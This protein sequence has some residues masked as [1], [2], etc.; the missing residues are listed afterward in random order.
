MRV[1]D[2][3]DRIGDG[4]KSDLDYLLKRDDI[5]LWLSIRNL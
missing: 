4:Y 3:R 2:K 1:D 5:I